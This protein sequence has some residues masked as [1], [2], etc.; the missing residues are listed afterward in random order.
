MGILPQTD[1]NES[2]GRDPEMAAATAAKPAMLPEKLSG[3][4]AHKIGYG[5][6]KQFHPIGP[7][8]EAYSDPVARNPDDQSISTRP[9]YLPGLEDALR[10][11]RNAN[12][13][14]L[15]GEST[16]YGL[17]ASLSQ[18]GTTNREL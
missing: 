1:G 14:D 11:R 4:Y 6:I 13:T 12:R 18:R 8:R 9:G 17:N 2:Q 16:A 3:G 7:V 15:P 10:R 5:K